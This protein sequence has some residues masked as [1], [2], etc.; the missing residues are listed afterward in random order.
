MATSVKSK[1]AGFLRGLL[2][3]GDDRTPGRRVVSA[4]SPPASALPAASASASNFSAPPRAAN[5]DEIELPLA[6]VVAAL[7]LDLRAI[8]SDVHV[9]RVVGALHAHGGTAYIQLAA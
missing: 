6:A 9:A 7:P 5:A 8:H 1:F 3:R 4:A 2:Q